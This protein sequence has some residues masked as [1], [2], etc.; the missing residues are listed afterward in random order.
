V[1]PYW[2]VKPESVT[3]YEVGYKALISKRLLLDLYAYRGAYKDFIT[4]RDAIQTV[5][6]TRR[7]FSLLLT[8]RRR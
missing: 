7:G 8:P 2:E 1:I 5:G 3:S 4:R 6:T